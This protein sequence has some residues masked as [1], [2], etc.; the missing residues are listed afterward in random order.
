MTGT[1]P[2]ADDPAEL[3]RQCW[4][5]LHDVFEQRRDLTYRRLANK[6]RKECPGSAPESHATVQG[7]FTKNK[8]LIDKEL[9]LALVAALGLEGE[10][11]AT[12]WEEWHQSDL[13]RRRRLRQES[14]PGRPGGGDMSEPRRSEEDPATAVE[15]AALDSSPAGLAIPRSP[16]ERHWRHTALMVTGAVAGSIGLAAILTV[17][18]VSI[19]RNLEEPEE[20]RRQCATVTARTGAP[21]YRDFDQPPLK[22]KRYGEQVEI[23]QALEPATKPE[24]RYLPVLVRQ[25]VEPT[26]GW[27]LDNQLT[28][29]TCNPR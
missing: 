9:F 25:G 8:K 4:E 14:R 6:L 15:P 18:A 11:W 24:G 3:A 7:W 10:R 28:P 1:G 20:P 21:V 16:G 27:V 5:E 26:F 12:R 23:Y 29:A 22:T 19:G 2:T 17:V 13:E